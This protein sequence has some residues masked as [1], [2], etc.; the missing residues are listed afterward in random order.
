ML[1]VAKLKECLHYDEMTGIFT[2][3][4]RPEAHFS[5]IRKAEYVN[6]RY[7]GKRA[8]KINAHGYR[9]IKIFGRYYREHRLAWMY[10]NGSL[11][12]D[13][14]DHINHSKTDNRIQNLR[15]VSPGENSRNRPAQSNNSSGCTGVYFDQKTGLWIPRIWVNRKQIRLGCY[16]SKEAAIQRRKSA[17]IEYGFHKNHG[18]Q[19]VVVA[20]SSATMTNERKD[21]RGN[22]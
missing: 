7:S 17:E 15:V 2:W 11:P 22:W 18:K 19:P 3:L 4:N 13:E 6:R 12:C 8:G 14:I 10:V 1:D 9:E 16:K 21:V 20:G 5:S